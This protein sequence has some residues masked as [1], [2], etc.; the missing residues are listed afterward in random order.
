MRINKKIVIENMLICMHDITVYICILP[1]G[2]SQKLKQMPLHKFAWQIKSVSSQRLSTVKVLCLVGYF[3]F[4]FFLPFLPSFCRLHTFLCIG[5]AFRLWHC[6]GVM[7][8]EENACN[9][10]RFGVMERFIIYI[11]HSLF[12][13]KKSE[14]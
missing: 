6:A 14:N 2:I 8:K 11:R 7:L 10:H 4:S 5:L 3:F 1:F 12:D 9:K 13:Q